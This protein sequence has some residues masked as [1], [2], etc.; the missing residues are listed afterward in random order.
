MGTP[1]PSQHSE[2]HFMA[3]VGWLRAAVLGANDGLLSTS[4]LMVGVAAAAANAGQLVLTGIA[5]IAAG[6]MAMAA[7]EYVSV[8]SQADSEKSDVE[9]ERR[10]H[11]ADPKHERGELVEIYI[12]RGLPRPLAEQVAEALMDR[13]ALGAHLRDELGIMDQSV[14][15]PFQAALASAFAFITG[16]AIPLITALTAGPERAVWAIVIVAILALALLGA[17]GAKAGGAP[18]ASAV[19]RVVMFGSLAMGVTAGVGHIFKLA[20]G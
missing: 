16:G 18:L 12:D 13:D 8:S 15:R 9:R 5:G 3:R 20:T 14:A 10:E 7:G 4:S 19:T 17:A 2:G 1:A 11:Q 6:A